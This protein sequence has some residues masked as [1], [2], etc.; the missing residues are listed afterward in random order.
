MYKILTI[1]VLNGMLMNSSFAQN[2]SLDESISYAL[3]NQENIKNVSIDRQIAEKKIKEGYALL[4]PQLK[5]VVD[6]RDNLILPTTILPGTFLNRPADQT[7]ATQF[8]LQYTS[9]AALDANWTIY[10]PTF[11]TGMKSLK[12]NNDIAANN[13]ELQ[14]TNA[15]LNVSKAYYAALLSRERLLL[16]QDNLTRYKLSLE[17]T[18]TLFGNQ[19]AQDIDVTR[20]QLNYANQ[21]PELRRS[22]KL[23]EQSL[24]MLKYQMGY[25]VDSM[26]V[27]TDTLLL[28]NIAP[29][30]VDG[31]GFSPENRIEYKSLRMQ[32]TQDILNV[33]K[34]KLAYLPNLSLY[35]Y[36]GGQSFKST[37]DFNSKWYGVS[38]LGV[39][40]NLPIFDGLQ[41]SALVQQSKLQLQKRDNDIKS[42]EKQYNYE[43]QNA[44]VNVDNALSMIYIRK[45]NIAIAE[46]LSGITQT[47]FSQGLVT[48]IEVV[49]S[50]NS[51]ID[52]QINHLSAL[53]DYVTAKL[54]FDRVVN[55]IK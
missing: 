53:Y 26:I 1:I 11:F 24:N 51:L 14:N 30:L 48:N 31:A 40:L 7:L 20:A 41:K 27:I 3:K 34:N 9:T 52:A 23:Y 29:E 25:P 22:Q 13:L 49:N 8:G 42:F 38:Y 39:K 18:K 35:G 16:A 10:D 12:L 45:N 36:F 43:I 50:Q 4:Y 2:F 46:K 47:R 5:G 15:K 32:K 6:M 33:R 28:K 37:L 44:K 19:Q 17:D 54:E 55:R 21:E